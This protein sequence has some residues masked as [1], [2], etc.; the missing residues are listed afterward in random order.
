[1]WIILFKC[2]FGKENSKG[3]TSL[4]KNSKELT[5][6]TMPPSLIEGA[7]TIVFFSLF[8]IFP[9]SLGILFLILGILVTVNIFHR[10]LWAYNNLN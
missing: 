9:E 5:S 3:K 1:M 8:F 2:C 7:E 6:I 10:L 4:K